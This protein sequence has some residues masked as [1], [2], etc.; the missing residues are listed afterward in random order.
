MIRQRKNQQWRSINTHTF[1]NQDRI[2]AETDVLQ[3][4]SMHVNIHNCLLVLLDKIA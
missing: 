4:V 1:K 2:F 3:Y